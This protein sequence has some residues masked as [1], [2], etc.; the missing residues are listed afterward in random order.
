[1]QARAPQPPAPEPA[2]LD[3]TE[4][5]YLLG[6]RTVKRGQFSKAHLQNLLNT[7]GTD[8][9]I[10]TPGLLAGREIVPADQWPHFYYL[11]SEGSWRKRYCTLPAVEEFEDTARPGT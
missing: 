11:H 10:V 9:K 7:L 1:M 8:K 6:G 3:K 2:A 4:P 5:R